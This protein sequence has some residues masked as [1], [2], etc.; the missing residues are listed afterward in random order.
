[1]CIKNR[2]AFDMDEIELDEVI[3]NDVPVIRR[4]NDAAVRTDAE[5]IRRSLA[6]STSAELEFKNYICLSSGSISFI[7]LICNRHVHLI[8]IFFSDF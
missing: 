4:A 8:K 6:N 2:V 7:F 5:Y 3:P 1:M